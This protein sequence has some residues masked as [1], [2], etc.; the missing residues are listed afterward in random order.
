MWLP[1][2]HDSLGID[3]ED[4]DELETLSPSVAPG[5]LRPFGGFALPGNLR[6]ATMQ[7]SSNKR[8]GD[9]TLDFVRR[10]D[11]ILESGLEMAGRTTECG[12][13]WHAAG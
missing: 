4:I 7:P 2:P 13:S 8:W 5:P 6:P 1:L 10:L 12:R 9:A 11:A 3:E